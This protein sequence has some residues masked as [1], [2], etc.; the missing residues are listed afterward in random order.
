MVRGRG[1]CI[2]SYHVTYRSVGLHSIPRLLLVVKVE[3]WLYSDEN[4]MART[5]PA[6]D[7]GQSRSGARSGGRGV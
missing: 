4:K 5:N 2:F 7:V 6:T 1:V 3:L